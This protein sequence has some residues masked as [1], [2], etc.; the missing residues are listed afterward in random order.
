MKKSLNLLL[1]LSSLLFSYLPSI[2]KAETGGTFTYFIKLGHWQ[3]TNFIEDEPIPNP[4][5]VKIEIWT[6]TKSTDSFAFLQN[7]K[8]GEFPLGQPIYLDPGSY[9]AQVK[10]L[11]E[12]ISRGYTTHLGDYK[13]K[14][15]SCPAFEIKGP[16][17]KITCTWLLYKEEKIIVSADRPSIA[18]PQIT[19]VNSSLGSFQFIKKLIELK[20]GDN[21]AYPF[22]LLPGQTI[23]ERISKVAFFSLYNKKVMLV[24]TSHSDSKTGYT[25]FPKRIKVSIYDISNPFNPRLLGEK[26][27]PN[28]QDSITGQMWGAVAVQLIGFYRPPLLVV[29]DHPVIYSLVPG[30][31]GA[32]V[33]SFKINPDWSISEIKDENSGKNDDDRIYLFSL[34]RG[35]D[36]K[37]YAIGNTYREKV[38]NKFNFEIFDVTS[39][40]FSKVAE[41]IATDNQSYSSPYLRP[42]GKISLDKLPQ[43]MRERGVINQ[44]GATGSFFVNQ[45]GKL[46]Y[47]AN[48]S[49]SRGRQH[50]THESNILVFDLTNPS[51]PVFIGAFKLSGLN[52]QLHFPDASEVEDVRI[53]VDRGS[54]EVDKVKGYIYDFFSHDYD[55]QNAEF[56]YVIF[57]IHKRPEW[58]TDA[59]YRYRNGVIIRKLNNEG[60]FNFISRYTLCEDDLKSPPSGLGKTCGLN[61]KFSPFKE[62]TKSL[63]IAFIGDLTRFGE[64]ND[65]SF[66]NHAYNGVV[67][68][69]DVNKIK[70]D[71]FGFDPSSASSDMLLYYAPLAVG[72][73]SDDGNLKII[74]ADVSGLNYNGEILVDAHLQQVDDKTFAIFQIHPASI[75]VVKLTLKDP[76]P[77]P[78]QGS[79]GTKATTS[80][81]KTSSTG[82]PLS[83]ESLQQSIFS[84][85]SILNVIKRILNR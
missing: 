76:R 84:I 85:K 44:V 58:P 11:E 10:G 69:R 51:I 4:Q 61:S 7:K 62:L 9:R 24:I 3:G 37:V 78:Q 67:L 8:I 38:A 16:S 26:I 56:A 66:G 47:L 70:L 57:G 59:S 27:I 19:E 5:K 13:E 1:L 28:D 29:D 14:G 30:S 74:P 52:G 68:L 15:S 60:G 20:D 55:H 40:T 73:V 53:Y 71:R 80:D 48:V 35:I 75:D 21:Y 33:V 82:T 79:V 12:I 83:L 49:V 50:A 22:S 41:V 46:Y 32:T 45:G 25:A 31:G 54:L 34:F 72:L 23:S 64:L 63:P 43:L 77:L 18:S 36:G 39:E 42:G 81:L 6:E 17:D 65:Y 2:I